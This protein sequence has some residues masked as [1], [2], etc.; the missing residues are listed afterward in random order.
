M[1]ES[2]HCPR[3]AVDRCLYPEMF[4]GCESGGPRQSIHWWDRNRGGAR[5]YPRS[6]PC[7]F[8]SHRWFV[9]GKTHHKPDFE[10]MTRKQSGHQRVSTVLL[11]FWT[12]PLVLPTAHQDRS[13]PRFSGI[14]IKSTSKCRYLHEECVLI[15]YTRQRTLG[16]Y[17]LANGGTT[18]VYTSLSP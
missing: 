2:W 1:H 10:R 17:T 12:T 5:L 15:F 16:Q 13:T 6:L 9:F 18:H 11:P 3:L 4:T 8:M 14:P 7:P